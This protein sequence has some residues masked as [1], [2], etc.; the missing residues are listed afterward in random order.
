ME[1]YPQNL[2]SIFNRVRENTF[3]DE[4]VITIM[5]NM[6]CS[7]NFI[8]SAGLIH[9]D[10]KPDNILLDGNCITKICDFGLSRP[11]QNTEDQIAISDDI[12]DKK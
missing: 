11:I 8:H 10:I 2:E 9:R 4:H 6:L 12:L 7:M 3:T 5:Y 1:H